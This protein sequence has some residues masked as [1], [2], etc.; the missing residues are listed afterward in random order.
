MNKNRKA[1]SLFAIL[2]VIVLL[3]I[4]A[5]TIV[6]NILFAG[7]KTPKVAGYYLYMHE[8]ADMQP[9]IPQNCLIMAKD[10]PNASL[11]PGNKVLCNLSDGTAAVRVIDQITVNEDGTSSYYPATALE[12]GTETA[13]PRGNIY[14]ICEWQSKD[15]YKYVNFTTSVGGIMALLVVPSV[16]LIIMVLAKIAKGS[17]DVLDE[18]DFLFDEMEELEMMTRKPKGADNPLFEPSQAPPAAESLE[19]KKSSISEHFEKKPVNENSPYQKAVQERTMK[20][21]IQQQNIEEAQRYEEASRNRTAGTQIF[22]SQ[23]VENAAKQ[24]TPAPAAPQPVQNVPLAPPLS[25][26]SAQKPSAPVRP[27]AP[28]EPAPNI[29]D[30]INPAEF[31]AAK[32]GQ[33]INPDIA[34]SGSIDDLLRVLEAEKK[35]L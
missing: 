10:A 12:Q 5:S 3:M 9:D 27:V 31:R 34:A 35:K 29:D 13:I 20:F 19:R 33:K 17:T 25:A 15:L 30:I 26:P 21:R 23:E 16:I 24:S 1:R 32:T 6:T 22:S 11:S 7:G 8:A 2:L 4:V 18:E 28:P 14:A